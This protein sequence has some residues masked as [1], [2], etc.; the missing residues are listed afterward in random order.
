MKTN[1]HIYREHMIGICEYLIVQVKVHKQANVGSTSWQICMK[2]RRVARICRQ[3]ITNTCI[4]RCLTRGL[5]SEQ[6]IKFV[7]KLDHSD[8]L[9]FANLTT[10]KVMIKSNHVHLQQS[11]YISYMHFAELFYL[12]QLKQN[13]ILLIPFLIGS[14]SQ[15]MAQVASHYPKIFNKDN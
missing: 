4:T 3:E 9:C 2:S 7:F 13:L 15:D 5:N 14:Q 11:H 10:S 12:E 8:T 1:N 6:L